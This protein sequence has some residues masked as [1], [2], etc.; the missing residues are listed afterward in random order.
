M[1]LLHA[2]FISLIIFLLILVFAYLA[3]NVTFFSSFTIAAAL[4]AFALVLCFPPILVVGERP[5]WLIILYGFILVT[6]LIVIMFYLL[7][8][9]FTDKRCCTP[10]RGSTRGLSR[11]KFQASPV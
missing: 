5:C 1:E 10:E 8:M 6:A 9:C 3:L 7:V 4:S 11:G 2:L